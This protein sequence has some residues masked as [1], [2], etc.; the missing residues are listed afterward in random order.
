MPSHKDPPVS[1][2]MIVRYWTAGLVG[3][4]VVIGAV[5]VLLQTLTRTAEQI[6]VGAAEIWRIGKLIANNT[7]HI[8]LIARSNQHAASILQAADGIAAAT[9]RIERAVV[10]DPTA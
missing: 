3:G 6:Q 2:S 4:L 8:P 7:V 1:E 9:G 5:A 10:G